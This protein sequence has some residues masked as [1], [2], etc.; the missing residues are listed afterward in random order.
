MTVFRYL[1]ESGAA[2]D[3]WDADAVTPLM[4]AACEG[5]EEVVALLIGLGARLDVVDKDDKSVLY[6]AAEQN[7]PVVVE[8]GTRKSFFLVCL[9]SPLKI[10]YRSY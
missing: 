3:L 7:H 1:H 10:H 4:I 9:S 5:H 2:L 8:V 6:H